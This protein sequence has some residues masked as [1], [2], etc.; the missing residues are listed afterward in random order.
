MNHSIRSLAACSVLA[1][2]L[3]CAWQG[4]AQEEADS[5]GILQT[6]PQSIADLQRLEAR[7]QA[8]LPKVLPALVCIELS[9]SSGTGVI[10]DDH[11]TIF[12]AAHVIDKKGTDLKIILT[13][14]TRLKAKTTMSSTLEEKGTDAGIAELTPKPEQ[15]VPFVTRTTTLPKVGDWVFSLGH[16][17]GLDEKRGAMVRLGR[18]VSIKNGTIQTDCKLI[19]GDS[20]GPLFNMN[21][22]LIGIHSRVGSGLEDNLH[23]P[24]KDFEP[25]A[26][27]QKK[28]EPAAANN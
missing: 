25:Q 16:G 15:P 21:G 6:T 13:D 1:G 10:V 5:T 8:M 2:G 7:L 26:A 22:E 11:G 18:V 24:M 23:V 27:E 17:G 9:D 28:A 14:G 19:R 12:T 3:L 20:G 4:K